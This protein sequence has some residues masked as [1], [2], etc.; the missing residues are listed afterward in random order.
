MTLSPLPVNISE[1]LAHLPVA[2]LV[3]HIRT[4]HCLLVEQGLSFPKAWIDELDQAHL[5]HAGRTG[6]LA[7]VA[8]AQ[9]VALEGVA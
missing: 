8:A 9:G 6:T 1:L 7:Q 3:A 4:A 2:G 5:E